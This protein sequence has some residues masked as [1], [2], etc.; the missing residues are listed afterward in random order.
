MSLDMFVAAGI[1]F[2]LFVIQLWWA[3]ISP[4]VFVIFWFFLTHPNY[5]VWFILTHTNYILTISIETYFYFY[6]AQQEF[7]PYRLFDY[8]NP[9]LYFLSPLT[10]YVL[11]SPIC[12][13]F[14]L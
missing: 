7:T 9:I 4:P 13:T 3:G 10:I 5:I 12:L 11:M 14:H 1:L 6:F 8:N 2:Q